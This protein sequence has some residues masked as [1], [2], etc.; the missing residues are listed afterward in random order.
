MSRKRPDRDESPEI[1]AMIG[2][3]LNA[4]VRRAAEG[5]EGALAALVEVEALAP[6]A[7]NAAVALAREVYSLG[8]LAAHLGVTRGA[9]AQRAARPLPEGTCHAVCL[10]MARCR[11]VAA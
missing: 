9:V 8:E 3:M 6:A 7:T 2:R 10:G 5:D 11:M 4:L 1:G